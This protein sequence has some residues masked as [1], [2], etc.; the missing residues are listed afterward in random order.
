MARAPALTLS[1]RSPAWEQHLQWAQRQFLLMPLMHSE[2]IVDQRLSLAQYAR[3]P[4][5]FGWSF[6][7]THYRAVARF[8]RF[9][10][11]NAA[12]GRTS[13]PAELRAVAHGLS[14]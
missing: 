11:R 10:H 6:A 2:R 1:T 3:L 12:L 5:R 9:P 13:T 7:Q 8:G 14:W 4:R